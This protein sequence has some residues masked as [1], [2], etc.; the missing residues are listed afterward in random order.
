MEERKPDQRLDDYLATLSK[1]DLE[2][3][4]MIRLYGINDE[5]TVA[6]NLM[7]W[8]IV[9][10]IAPDLKWDFHTVEAEYAACPEWCLDLKDIT[11]DWG[12]SVVERP[13]H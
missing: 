12:V 7:G 10:Q 6:L 8:K 2:M 11:P 3:W 5:H 9:S 1:E 13:S 4:C